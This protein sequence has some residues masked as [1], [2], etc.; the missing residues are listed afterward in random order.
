MKKVIDRYIPDAIHLIAGKKNEQIVIE[1]EK[2]RMS[3]DGKSVSKE[4]RGYISSFGASL[5]QAGLLPTLA[6]Y[7]DKEANSA[8]SR[9]KILIVFYHLLKKEER[10]ENQFLPASD[11]QR[12]LQLA[13]K[14]QKDGGKEEALRLLKQDI[15]N[16]AIA[17]KLALRTYQLTENTTQNE[18]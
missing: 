13:L 3:I 14:L 5:V 8:Q 11:E 2:N 9:W 12:L 15:K 10:W 16:A 6:F 7:A 18:Q 17:L 4:F 1:Q